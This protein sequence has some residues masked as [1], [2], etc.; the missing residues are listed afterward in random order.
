MNNLI[1]FLPLFII[2]AVLLTVI[3][4]ELVKKLDKNDKLKNYRAWVPVLF[5]AFFA[6]LLWHGAFFAPREVWFWWAAIFGI[7]VFFYETILK[8][9]K[10]A[11]DENHKTI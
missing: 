8:K 5:S 9:I 4:T 11:F 1:G 3:F 6:F 10:E 2:I 7:S